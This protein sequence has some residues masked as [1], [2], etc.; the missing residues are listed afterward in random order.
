VNQDEIRATVLRLLGNVAP[1][2]DLQSLR[3]DDVLRDTID[4]DS[5]DFLSFLTA[6]S[7]ELSVEIPE[8]DYGALATLDGCVAYLAAARR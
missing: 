6:V 8:S 1:E 3:G 7:E 2:A 5:M 4:L